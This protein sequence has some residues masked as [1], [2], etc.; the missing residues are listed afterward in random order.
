M[1]R[2]CKL[3]ITTRDSVATDLAALSCYHACVL[4]LKKIF[5]TSFLLAGL[6]VCPSAALCGF[7]QGQSERHSGPPFVRSTASLSR[8]YALTSFQSQRTA[9]DSSRQNRIKHPVIPAGLVPGK[10]GAPNAATCRPLIV[11]D[12]HSLYFSAGFSRP[13]VRGPPPSA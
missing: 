8:N 7:S 11:R 2:Q 5:L 6:I 9:S 3:E 1:K 13:V 12:E 10:L 4:L